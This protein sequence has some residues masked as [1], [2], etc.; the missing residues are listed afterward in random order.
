MLGYRVF[1]YPHRVEQPAKPAP[2]LLAQVCLTGA[3][4]TYRGACQL[5]VS[6]AVTR[7]YLSEQ[8]VWY[9]VRFPTYETPPILSR[10]TEQ[11]G[12]VK[13]CGC[14]IPNG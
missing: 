13:W 4:S 6:Y 11:G 8:V 9:R 2:D 5:L 3:L 12:L 1:T 7:A 14:D 10:E